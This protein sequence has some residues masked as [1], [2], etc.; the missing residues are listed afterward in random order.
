[1][2]ALCCIKHSLICFLLEALQ[3]FFVHLLLLNL[4]YYLAVDI[5]PWRRCILVFALTKSQTI[6]R[7][8]RRHFQHQPVNVFNQNLS[9]F[10]RIHKISHIFA[11]KYCT[12]EEEVWT[13]LNIWIW[14]PRPLSCI[15]HPPPFL[16]PKQRWRLRRRHLRSAL[17]ENFGRILI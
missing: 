13:I 7:S 4:N 8:F 1:M 11:I 2:I 10:S 9:L 16:E 14:S 5:F 15:V 3:I 17:C 6:I 12:N